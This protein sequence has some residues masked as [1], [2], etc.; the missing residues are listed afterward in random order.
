MIVEPLKLIALNK[1]R[2]GDSE[3]EGNTEGGAGGSLGELLAGGEKRDGDARIE[4]DARTDGVATA[5]ASKDGEGR[6][7]GKAEGIGW[8]ELWVPPLVFRK[9]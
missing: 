3:A 5:L 6:I 9:Y 7:E 1:L 4:G 8:C 2:S